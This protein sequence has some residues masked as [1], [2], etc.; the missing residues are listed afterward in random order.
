[1]C[2]DCN[3]MNLVGKVVQGTS[4]TNGK[5]QNV[6]NGEGR[7]YSVE[8]VTYI[9]KGKLYNF[10]LRELGCSYQFSENIYHVRRGTFYNH[11]KH[12]RKVPQKVLDRVKATMKEFQE[13]ADKQKKILKSIGPYVV[14]DKS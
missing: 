14:N 1:M 12:V 8:G 4:E 13:K 3:P 10:V 7:F 2:Y 11:F 9:E 5:F 6:S